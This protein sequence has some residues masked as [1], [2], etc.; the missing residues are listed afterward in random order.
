MDSNAIL[1]RRCSDIVERRYV[2]IRFNAE[3]DRSQEAVLTTIV[4]TSY[5]TLT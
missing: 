2:F 4:S 3:K 5:K 1:F